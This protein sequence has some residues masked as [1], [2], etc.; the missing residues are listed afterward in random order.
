MKA[1]SAKVARRF[2]SRAKA[3]GI[4]QAPPALVNR[5]SKWV[6]SEQAELSYVIQSPC[7]R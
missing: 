7:V 4:L 1:N 6:V 5:V 3:G 2:A